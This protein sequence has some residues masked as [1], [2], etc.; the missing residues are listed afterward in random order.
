MFKATLKLLLLAVWALSTTPLV[1]AQPSSHWYFGAGFGQGEVEVI[2]HDR[3][4]LIY[5]RLAQA[6]LQPTTTIGSED[7]NTNSRKLYGG[8]RIK[9]W[10]AAELS[11]HDL[12]HTTGLF[13]TDLNSVRATGNLRSEYKAISVSGVG[14]WHLINHLSLLA[15]VG[16]HHWQH[17]FDL[18]S[19]LIDI[20]DTRNGNGLLYGAGMQLSLW[21]NLSLRLE[22]ERLAD[23]EDE[24]GVDT[25]TL[26][27]QW[28]F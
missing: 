26:S 15:K 24:E 4:E 18:D 19:A 10:L 9:P 16:I 7:D 13:A 1:A 27:L 17:Q 6:G 14:E 25:K 12:G 3:S 22:W 5:Q 8:Y 21:S 11:Y 2:G 23:I 20:S 28:D